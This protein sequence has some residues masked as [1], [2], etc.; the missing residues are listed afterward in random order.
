MVN[1][2]SSSSNPYEGEVG[3]SDGEGLTQHRAKASQRKKETRVMVE[4]THLSI[5]H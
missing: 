4:S 2:R 5:M 3:D 1:T